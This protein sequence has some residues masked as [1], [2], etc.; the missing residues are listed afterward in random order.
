MGEHPSFFEYLF[1]MAM[2]FFAKEEVEAAVLESPGLAG[3]LDATNV[4]ES[5]VLTV[6]TSISLEHTEYLG[7]TIAAIAGEKAGIIKQGVPVGI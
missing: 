5:P 7:N 6:I 1:A 4:I 2:V 3:R